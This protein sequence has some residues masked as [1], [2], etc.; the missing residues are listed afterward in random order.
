MALESVSSIEEPILTLS[1]LILKA[2]SDKLKRSISG[3]GHSAS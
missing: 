1:I 2:R 3:K